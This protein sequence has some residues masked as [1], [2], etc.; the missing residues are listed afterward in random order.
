VV[1]VT[2]QRKHERMKKGPDDKKAAVNAFAALQ[3][4]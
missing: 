4:R 2:R 1:C 3:V